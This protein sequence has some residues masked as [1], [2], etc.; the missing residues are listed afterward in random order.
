MFERSRGLWNNCSFRISV[1][2]SLLGFSPAFSLIPSAHAEDETDVQELQKEFEKE[3][4]EELRDESAVDPSKD[5]EFQEKIRRRREIRERL[6]E[7]RERAKEHHQEIQTQKIERSRERKFFVGGGAIAPFLKKST[8][9]EAGDKGWWPTALMFN[10]SAA[11]RFRV[12]TEGVALAP[13]LTFAPLGSRDYESGVRSR[14][15]TLS[16]PFSF[17]VLA[18]NPE[19]SLV[20][21]ELR[22][23][24]GIFIYNMQGAGGEVSLNNGN[25]TTRF[26][27]PGLSSTA[28]LFL[29][30][31]G[32]AV[33]FPAPTKR[34]RVELDGLMT[35]ALSA[36]RTFGAQ[37]L[38]TYGLPLK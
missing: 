25:T 9:N 30:Q 17:D 31:G 11:Y 28:T 12:F 6:R 10:I 29:V 15:I 21:I 1:A 33:N 38:F 4:L 34:Y 20:G 5:Q 7:K 19:T 24:P 22:L 2:L 35:G 3:N 37:L 14:V 36:R 8:K 32:L 16:A 13:T 26:Y 18:S 27:L 23:G